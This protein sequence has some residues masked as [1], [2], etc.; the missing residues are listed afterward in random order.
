MESRKRSVV[1]GVLLVSVLFLVGCNT[2]KGAATGVAY[3][4][5]STAEGVAKDAKGVGS[6]I[7]KLDNW[8][9]KNLW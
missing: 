8:I 7:V 3:G 9:K 2:A 4:V 5:G 6:A 1:A